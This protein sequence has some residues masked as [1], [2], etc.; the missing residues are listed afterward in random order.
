[1]M[2]GDLVDTLPNFA[3]GGGNSEMFSSR[4]PRLLQRSCASVAL[5]GSL[6]SKA[7]FTDFFSSLFY[8]FISLTVSWDPL[9]NEVPIF[10]SLFWT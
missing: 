2:D 7:S 6:L 3:L 8:F 9:P 1:M 5:N 4:P 10:T